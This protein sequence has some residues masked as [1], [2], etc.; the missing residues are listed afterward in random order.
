MIWQNLE[1]HI[2][3]HDFPPLNLFVG[4]EKNQVTGAKSGWEN[5][6]EVIKKP[7]SKSE[8][9]QEKHSTKQANDLSAIG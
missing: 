1:K 2:T 3:D 5:N 7:R 8:D 4:S 9:V 6:N